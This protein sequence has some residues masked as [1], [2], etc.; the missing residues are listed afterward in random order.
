LRDGEFEQLRPVL[1]E[2]AEDLYEDAPCGYLSTLPGGELVRVNRTLLTW[3]GYSREELLGRRFQDLLTPGGRI[4]HETHYAPLL[5][6]QGSV[7]EIA[8]D[9]VCADGRRLPVLVNSVLRT[10]DDDQ[11]LF[12]RTT[13]FDATH[14]REY[15]REL[16][17][18]R[19]RERAARQRMERLQQLS[20]VLAAAVDTREMTAAVVRAL[21]DDLGADEVVVALL[22]AR[23][24]R[25]EVV[26]RRG[27]G[28]TDDA[29]PVGGAVAVDAFMRKILRAG[30]PSR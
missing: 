24:E 2:R 10:D 17:R 23:G 22:D 9:L 1:D 15:E 20:A 6:M 30:R 4:Y 14:R 7:R 11:P 18:A 19:E 27:A 12:V 25:L 8:L 21:A 16:V 28:V 5:R 3:T 13:V 26:G 29:P